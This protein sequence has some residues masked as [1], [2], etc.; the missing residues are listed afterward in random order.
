MKGKD[1][2]LIPTLTAA[3]AKKLIEAGAISDG[4][5]PK[6]ECCI[7]ALKGSVGKTHVLDG[8]T[9]HAILLEIFTEAG[10]G[11]EVVADG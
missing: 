6:V 2:K 7:A 5:I 8:R 1:G 4:M 11:T 10:V 3:A 9:P